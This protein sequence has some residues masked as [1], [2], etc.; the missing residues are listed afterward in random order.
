[1]CKLL[2][3]E[4]LHSVLVVPNFK[5]TILFYDVKVRI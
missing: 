1:M 2:E 4:D 5:E 3:A